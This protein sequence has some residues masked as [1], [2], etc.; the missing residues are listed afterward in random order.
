MFF[1]L[2]GVLQT[3]IVTTGDLFLLHAQ[4]ES[5]LLFVLVALFGAIVFNTIVYTCV[6]ILGNPGKAVAI[7]L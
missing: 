3:L 2:M 5:P 1:I 7:I 6:S 4:V